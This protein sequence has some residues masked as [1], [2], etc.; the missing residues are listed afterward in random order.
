MSR[1]VH[2]FVQRAARIDLNALP[3]AP[4]LYAF[5]GRSASGW[6]AA[7][8]KEGGGSERVTRPHSSA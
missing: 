4:P 3:D 8:L 7:S 2:V 6:V 5:H 1:R